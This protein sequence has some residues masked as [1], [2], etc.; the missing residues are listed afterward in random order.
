MAHFDISPAYW[1]V[2]K[3]LTVF[4][5]WYFAYGTF[6]YRLAFERTRPWTPLMP[7]QALCE[8]LALQLPGRKAEFIRKQ[9]DASLALGDELGGYLNSKDKDWSHK[10]IRDQKLYA[11]VGTAMLPGPAYVLFV[12]APLLYPVWFSVWNSI[13]STF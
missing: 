10:N 2:L 6:A 4:T 3:Y 7:F 5:L 9:V 11:E 1:E 13:R 8:D 12:T